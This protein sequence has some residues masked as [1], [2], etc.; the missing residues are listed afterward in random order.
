MHYPIEIVAPM[1]KELTDAGFQE[2]TSPEEVDAAI[3]DS[4]G[5]VFIVINSV[6]GCSAGAARPAAKM[7]IANEKKPDAIYTV[8]AGYDLEATNRV[9]QY[10]LPYPASSPS[11]ALFKDGKLVHFLERHHIEGNRA[12][13]ITTHLKEVFNTYC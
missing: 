12:E 3:A 13:A 4:K 8:F 2:L 9:R 7:A 10:A 1:K 11:M 5:T 6:C